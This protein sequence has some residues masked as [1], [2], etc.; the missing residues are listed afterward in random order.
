[1]TDRAPPEPAPE[2]LQRVIET[3]E[4][5]LQRSHERVVSPDGRAAIAELREL[6]SELV[7]ALVGPLGQV[8]TCSSCKRSQLRTGSR[9]AYCWHR[10]EAA[11]AP[12]AQNI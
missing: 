2:T 5:E 7:D 8:R 11:T 9:C 10:L 3:F 1:M 6:W 4:R 12:V